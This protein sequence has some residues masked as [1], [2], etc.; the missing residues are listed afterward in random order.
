[1]LVVKL[2]TRKCHK[3]HSSPSGSDIENLR[4][5]VHIMRIHT[6]VRRSISLLY[7][8][9]SSITSY[10]RR[11]TP[12]KGSIRP[13][14]KQRCGSKR[15]NSASAIRSDSMKGHSIVSRNRISTNARGL[16][17]MVI[18]FTG[19]KGTKSKKTISWLQALACWSPGA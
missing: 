9:R 1:M 11:T 6:Q 5:G 2:R 17:Q 4:P 3:Q 13:S 8:I 16:S 12:F 15:A 18:S 7:S 14:D 19:Q 10:L